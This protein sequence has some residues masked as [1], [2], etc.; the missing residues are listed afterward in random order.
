MKKDSRLVRCTAYPSPRCR[1]CRHHPGVGRRHGLRRRG[2]EGAERGYHAMADFRDAIPGG[3]RDFGRGDPR[4]RRQAPASCAALGI[5]AKLSVGRDLDPLLHVAA[6]AEPRDGVGCRLYVADFRG[7]GGRPVLRRPHRMAAMARRPDRLRRRGR[8]RAARNRRILLGGPAAARRG[9]PVWL[10]HGDHAGEV[11]RGHGG[12]LVAI[13]RDCHAGYR[14]G[15]MRGV[16]D[17]R[18]GAGKPVALPV[19]ARTLGRDEPVG[20]GRHRLSGPADRAVWGGRRPGLS[21]RH[22]V[23]R[24]DLR[25]CLSDLGRH[26]GASSFSGRCRTRSPSP[27]WR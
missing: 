2:G 12:D 22:V 5:G 23:G 19:P 17:L 11:S 27:A 13:P 26:L 6:D 10:C 21:D 3:G 24:R 25:L 14:T 16:G 8:Y 4:R 15:R 20:L 9:G 18:S 1:R 7:S